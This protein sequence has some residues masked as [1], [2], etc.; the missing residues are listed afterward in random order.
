MKKAFPLRKRLSAALAI[1]LSVACFAG[2]VP[3]NAT[4]EYSYSPVGNYGTFEDYMWG[5]VDDSDKAYELSFTAV[6]GEVGIPVAAK[7]GSDSAS[8]WAKLYTRKISLTAGA[9]YQV[10]FK[11]KSADV[12]TNS[13]FKRKC[14][15]IKQCINSNRKCCYY[16]FRNYCIFYIK[17]ICNTNIGI[18]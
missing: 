13:R 10:S 16:Y 14:K 12:N 7:T 9:K 8:P 15:N 17:K 1:V 18:K 4:G 5:I 2:A 6:D 3:A 11:I